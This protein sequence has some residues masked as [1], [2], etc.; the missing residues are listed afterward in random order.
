ML[1]KKVKENAFY[2]NSAS[3]VERDF[4]DGEIEIVEL[5][6]SYDEYNTPLPTEEVEVLGTYAFRLRGVHSNDRATFG[7]LGISLSHTIRIKINWL[8]DA[9]MTARINGELYD[10]VKV[11]PDVDYDELELV[12]AKHEKER[13]YELERE[14]IS[15]LRTS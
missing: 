13:A 4:S 7:N 2:K 3:L 6:P 9:G 15:R 11:Y 10:I 5:V 12:L 14:N 8:I 1:N